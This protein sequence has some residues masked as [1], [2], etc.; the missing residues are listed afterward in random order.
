MSVAPELVTDEVEHAV[1]VEI[2][3]LIIS[4]CVAE[5]ELALLLTFFANTLQ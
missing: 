5:T 1:G 4:V 3:L 2:A